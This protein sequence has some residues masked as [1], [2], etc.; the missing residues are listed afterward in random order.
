[1]SAL[2]GSVAVA[3]L[4]F[5]TAAEA[6]AQWAA[7][8]GWHRLSVGVGAARADSRFTPKSRD[9]LLAFAAF[10]VVARRHFE[11]RFTGS[12]FQG[13]ESTDAQVGGVGLDAVLFPW[14]GRVQPYVG[15]GAAVYESNIEDGDPT[16]VTRVRNYKGA[17]GTAL[18]GTRVRIGP[19]VPFV[20]ARLT[21]FASDSPVRRYA[22]LSAGLHF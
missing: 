18:V 19:L 20:E 5:V 16:A 10:E 3:A 1:M 7:P 21:N 4:L 6:T 9:G 13:T 2:R 8:A 15:V 17:A 22:A 14:R 12:F 11:V